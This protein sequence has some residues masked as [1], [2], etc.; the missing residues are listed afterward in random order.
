MIDMN[1]RKRD[2]AQ[3]TARAG[4][5][6][7]KFLDLIFYKRT[8]FR[9]HLYYGYRS[10]RLDSL[11]MLDL[12]CSAGYELSTCVRKEAYIFL[13]TYVLEAKCV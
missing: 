9:I 2:T 8:E 13:H 6:V 5:A 1:F 12:I 11:N 7:A 10:F 3:M 4:V